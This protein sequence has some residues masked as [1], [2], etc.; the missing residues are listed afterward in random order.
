MDVL[1]LQISTSFL[2]KGTH[3][4]EPQ[5]GLYYLAEYAKQQGY[6]VKIKQFTSED[7]IVNTSLSILHDNNC[8]VVGFYVDSDNQWVVRRVIIALKQREQIKCII[9]GPQVTGNG[10]LALKRM[11][12]VDIAI[13]GE[14]EQTLSE[15]I[16]CEN[17]SFEVLKRIKGIA[18]KD[19]LGHYHYTGSRPFVKDIDVYSFPKRNEYS[20]DNGLEFQTISTGR[21]CIGNCSFCFE[22]NKKENKL[23]LRSIDSVIEEVDY[24]VEHLGEHKY[25]SFLDDTFIIYPE[26]VRQLCAHLINKY[27]GEIK[28]YCEARVDILKDNLDLLPLMKQAGLARVQLGGESGSQRILDAY[29]KK[30][31]PEQLVH[32]VRAIFSAGIE[33]IYINF[34]IGG[35]FETLETFNDTVELAKKLIDV[36]PR[37]ASVGCSLFTPY[38]GTPMREHPDNYGITIF[39]RDSIYGRDGIIPSVRTDELSE[40]KLL[41]LKAIFYE[42]VA[43]K[44]YEVLAKSSKAE[45]NKL[46]YNC[47]HYGLASEWY[48]RCQTIELIKNYHEAIYEFGYRSIQD[49][50]DEELGYAVPFRVKQIVSDGE[51]YLVETAPGTYKKIVGKEKDVFML[52]SGKLSHMEI[53]QIIYQNNIWKCSLPMIQEILKKI[54]VGFDTEYLVV[55]KTGV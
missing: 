28:W 50:A 26:R 37:C 8:H 10:E 7:P 52:S 15:I 5:L 27:N 14:G 31:T 49:I 34:I 54:Y 9:G 18:F 47:Y 32:V 53:V 41:Q 16:S 48:E 11:P 1:L 43:K 55:W 29:N 12:L 39:D 25:I 23:R 38:V 2:G 13:I 44:E 3:T 21:G 30:M 22:G 6:N 20:L 17:S 40:Y 33:S 35:A 46:Y 19:D 45:I 36:A 24:L 51:N 42:E 4:R